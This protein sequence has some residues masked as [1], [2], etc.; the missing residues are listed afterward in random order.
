[1]ALR[2]AAFAW[3]VT[4]G[5][6]VV[7]NRAT[8][9]QDH[10]WQPQPDNAALMVVS[11]HP[12]D[13]GIFFG[14][15]I[16][17]H[18][19]VRQLPMVLID[20]VSVAWGGTDN[21]IRE[22]ELRNAAWV[23]GMRNE[24][25]FLRVPDV[26]GAGQHI[27]SQGNYADWGGRQR[28][29]EVI[30]TNIRM[31]TPDV[32]ITHDFDGEYGHYGHREA[33][34]ATADAFLLAAD[35]AVDLAG[36]EAWQASKLYVHMYNRPSSRPVINEL[37]Q[38]WSVPYLELDGRTP[39]DVAND[40]LAEHVS[41]GGAGLVSAFAGRRFS[42]Q[43]GLYASTVGADTTDTDGIAWGGFFENVD[44]DIYDPHDPQLLGDLNSDQQ[45]DI[46]DWRIFSPNFGGQGLSWQDG[47][48]DFDTDIDADDFHRF[49]E[50]YLRANPDVTDASF[51][52]PA[53][54]PEP[55]SWI[56]VLVFAGIGCGRAVQAACS[57]HAVGSLNC[58]RPTVV[59]RP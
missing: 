44:L 37:F 15:A 25:I 31:Y 27:D 56:L 53:G 22:N 8:H 52:F 36:L 6:I 40:G 3:C 55:S 28:L 7:G 48:M 45:I 34:V 1:M 46:F 39:L 35:P 57:R 16:P 23:Y 38:D 42:Q 10:D 17:Y 11:A 20:T 21:S 29:A 32:I 19:Q 58:P 18:A 5:I 47:D 49:K 4:I 14:G 2:N 26:G 33:A 59:A 12:D 30:A 51:P 9:A 41:Q 54:V 13:E 43:W 50:A 24:P